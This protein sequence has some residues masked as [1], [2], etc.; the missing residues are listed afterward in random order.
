[1]PR[2]GQHVDDDQKQTGLTVSCAAVRFCLSASGHADNSL[3]R[4]ARLPFRRSPPSTR[5][6]AIGHDDPR[7]LHRHDS[8]H[9]LYRGSRCRRACRRSTGIRAD[10]IHRQFVL[11]RT[12]PPFALRTLGEAYYISLHH[13]VEESSQRLKASLIIN[14]SKHI[15]NALSGFEVLGLPSFR[16]GNVQKKKKKKNIFRTCEYGVTYNIQQ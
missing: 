1:M 13:H 9:L 6:G 8:A 12:A 5:S 10:G 2:Q 3:A 11:R 15:A 7:R 14:R 16:H 4:G